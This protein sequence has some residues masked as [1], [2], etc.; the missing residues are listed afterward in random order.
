M[1]RLSALLTACCVTVL[2][3]G[4]YHALLW[5]ISGPGINKPSYLYGTMHTTDSRVFQFSN[6]VDPAFKSARRFA[7]ELNPDEA[8]N[9]QVMARLLMPETQSLEQL[10]DSVDYRFLDSIFT[11]NM[12]SSLALF[13]RVSPILIEAMVEQ[14]ALKSRVDEPVTSSQERDFLDMYFYRRA[15][16]LHKPVIGLEAVEDQLNALNSLTY[17]E[18]AQLLHDDLITL[19]GNVPE[20]GKNVLALYV[21]QDLDALLKESHE[22]RLPPK[23]YTAIVTVRNQHMARR[24]SELVLE[25]PTFIAVG[26]LHLPGPEGVIELLRQ[27]GF[28]VT[29]QN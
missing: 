1:K 25:K 17:Q 21:T 8:F 3:F 23:F 27:K 16:R 28:T 14:F 26:A 11:R 9:A 22:A 6:Q 4:Q 13:N 20:D 15:K 19:R 29:P 18:Q 2:G 24:I 7:M 12:G 10:L 5:K